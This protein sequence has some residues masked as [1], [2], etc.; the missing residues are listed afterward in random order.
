MPVKANESSN[1]NRSA[2]YRSRNSRGFFMST[3]T[4]DDTIEDPVEKLREDE[5]AVE[6]FKR[7]ADS[8]AQCA[9]RFQNA[10]EKA[11]VR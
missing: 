2:W 1:F 7:L 4:T 9:D 11:G 10:L 8:N 5:E 6:L 3:T